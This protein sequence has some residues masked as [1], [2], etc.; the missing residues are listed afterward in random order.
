MNQVRWIA[1]SV[2]TITTLIQAASPADFSL[3]A[4][5]KGK[6]F[7]LSENRGKYV[8]LHFLLKTECPYCLRHTASYAARAREQ[9]NVVHVFIKPDTAQEIAKWAP[10]VKIEGGA[11]PPVIHRDPNAALA[12][13]YAI[14][15][16]YQFHG[17]TTHYPALVLLNPKGKEVFRYVGKGNTDRYKYEDFARKLAE[18]EGK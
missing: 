6:P 1:L 11:A 13:A 8:A 14:P 5:P 4:V 7:K 9:P 16:G 3:E 2:L 12:K 18:L 15:D 17:Q 10:K